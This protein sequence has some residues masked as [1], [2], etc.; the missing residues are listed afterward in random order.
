MGLDGAEGGADGGWSAPDRARV[1]LCCRGVVQGVGFRPAVHRLAQRLGLTGSLENRL[2]QVVLELSGPRLA[3]E[4][5]LADLPAA[6][7]PQARLEPLRPQWLPPLRQ[8]PQQL[9]I[10]ASA[11]VPVGVGL[12]AP[13]LA[14]D[15]APCQACLAELRDPANRRHRYP[16]IS[17]CSC[18]PRYTIATAEPYA[19]AHTT[20]AGFELCQACQR[21]FADP[22]DRR[23]HAETI[24]CPRCGPQLRWLPA[25]NPTADPLAAAVALLRAGGI[26]GLQGVGGFQLL[27]DA[28]NPDAIARLRH[29]KRRPHKPLA[30]LVAQ[31]DGLE[32]W[33]AL[34]SAERQLLQDPAAPIVLLRRRVMGNGLPL[35][36][37][38][39]SDE[40]GVMLPASPLHQL[41]ADEVG[42]PLVATSGNPSGEPLCTT[43]AEARARLMDA[44]TPIADGLLVH[45][46][47]IARRLDDSVL[48]CIDGQPQLLRRARGY[49]PAALPLAAPSGAALLALG[50]DLKSAPAL[51][52]GDRLWLAPHLGDLADGRSH[53]HWQAG[54]AELLDRHDGV[55]QAICSDQHPGYTSVQWAQELCRHR[56]GLRH[57]AVQHHQAHGLAVLAERGQGPPAL[58][59][60]GDGLGY[61]RAQGSPA[62]RLWGGEGL[63]LEADGRCRRL[64]SLRPFPLP[65]A[66]RAIAEPRRSALGLLWAAGA[67]DHPGAAASL[68]AFAAPERRLLLQALAAGCQSPLTSSLGRLFDAVAS[69][70]DLLQRRSFEGQGG[71][72]LQGAA[73]TAPAPSCCG[74]Y[75]LPVVAAPAAAGVAQW[76][77]W[78][79]LLQALLADRAAGVAVG[80]CALRVHHALGAAIAAWAVPLA[81]VQPRALPVVLAGGCFQNRL[82]LQGAIAAL[83]AA[84]LQPLWG[85]QVPCNDGG[86]ALGQLLA[87]RLQPT[88]PA[89]DPP[90][91][92]MRASCPL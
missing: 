2:G 87:V 7:P 71:V 54:L 90:A 35:N 89:A 49:A 21:E 13:A 42:A 81:R 80:T 84:G 82:L 60:A 16:F 76:L 9:R 65:G 57:H 55:L 52:L 53:D 72:L 24:G 56:P 66:E 17:C 73:A 1:R 48:R 30:L 50:G 78:G 70:L 43:V 64:L 19:R 77:D 6:L 12:V 28:R 69:L 18:G 44:S 14:A 83:R 27:V 36:L 29:R 91:S 5:L 67:L 25:A 46:R 33:L 68:E 79:P 3:V 92:A 62:V 58:V 15:L 61:G 86:L 32:R 26:V 39:G 20:M 4:Q 85:Q 75:P 41:L 11:P 8:P 23:F 88:G 10:G 31:L 37:A 74:V 34:S 51:A 38:P 45:N 40:L 47:A 63:R 59:F 22:G